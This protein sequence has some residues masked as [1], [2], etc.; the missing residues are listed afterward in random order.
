VVAAGNCSAANPCPIWNDTTL[1]DSITQP[2]TITLLGGERNR[3]HLEDQ[4]GRLGRDLYERPDN[5]RRQLPAFGRN[6]VSEW[7]DA[8]VDLGSEFRGVGGKRFG[9]S[10]GF[11]RLF[12]EHQ[13]E[14]TADVGVLRDAA[15][16]RCQ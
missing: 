10:R 16:D 13:S 3:L 6:G 8:A 12:W 5:Q 7:F 9:H 1:Q 15:S 4:F 2:C 14:N 11:F